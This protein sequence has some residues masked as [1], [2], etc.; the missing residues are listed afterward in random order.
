MYDA[1][2]SDVE[3]TKLLLTKDHL[4]TVS[5]ERVHANM[6]LPELSIPLVF[7]LQYALLRKRESVC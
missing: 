1:I 4:F 7:D 5:E 2:L 6:T 3:A